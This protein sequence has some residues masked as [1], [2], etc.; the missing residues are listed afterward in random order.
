MHLCDGTGIVWLRLPNDDLAVHERSVTEGYVGEIVGLGGMLGDGV[1]ET[2]RLWACAR[3]RLVQAVDCGAMKGRRSIGM[4]RQLWFDFAA[5]SD[6]GPVR[7]RNEDAA[8][9]DAR[10][11]ALADGV[12][13]H[14]GGDLASA[15]MVRGFAQIDFTLEGWDGADHLRAAAFRGEDAIAEQVA[16]RPELDGM[17]TTLTAVLLQRDHRVVLL[18][19]GD[20]RRYLF[21]DR[22]LYQLSKDDTFV[23]SLVDARFSLA[24]WTVRPGDLL[25]LCSDG[26][27]DALSDD[28][29]EEVM[30]SSSH[31]DECAQRL[32]GQALSSGARDNVTCVVAHVVEGPP[33]GGPVFVGAALSGSRS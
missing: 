2:S 1:V 14:P 9:A 33:L 15:A 6:R 28:V 32:I 12:G 4:S 11:L 17:A 18:H 3:T 29:I 22:R 30:S 27:S 25:L 24:S 16:H 13:G 10:V 19:A 20:S 21:R 26:L 31:T 8:Y 5:G 7:E 23:Q